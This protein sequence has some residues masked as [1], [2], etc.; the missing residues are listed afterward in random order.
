MAALSVAEPTLARAQL[1]PK[2]VIPMTK[3]EKAVVGLAIGTSMVVLGRSIAGESAA[4][5]G[6]S[7]I[8]LTLL[9]GAASLAFAALDRLA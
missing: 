6:V 2:E 4:R 3:T 7:P 1:G 5:L 9:L 8:E